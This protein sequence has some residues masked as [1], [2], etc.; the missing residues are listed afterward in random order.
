MVGVIFTGNF[1][2]G[3]VIGRSANDRQAEGDV[4][5]GGEGEHFEGDQSLIMI[6]ADDGIEFFLG[7]VIEKGVGRI[8]AADGE[9]FFLESGNGGPE[10]AFFFIAKKS[11]LAGVRIDT[12]DGD[13]WLGYSQFTQKAD[14][15][16]GNVANLVDGKRAEGG[17]QA[18]MG[19]A[20]GNGQFGIGEDHD[21]IGSLGL[22]AVS[23][24]FG[25]AGIAK[26]D[27]SER[28][29]LNGAGD[30]GGKFSA[31]PTAEGVLEGVPRHVGGDTSGMAGF[32]F[33]GGSTNHFIAKA[34]RKMGIAQRFFYD[35]RTDAGGIAQ[36]DADD[37]MATGIG[38]AGHWIRTS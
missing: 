12:G 19:R 36:G 37:G 31:L 10:N 25:L 5:A 3:A 18:E 22:T 20:E 2:S 30:N 4:H 24:K 16:L 27:L 28:F 9:M 14:G 21:G 29:F 26:T 34:T 33:F 23:K 6:G 1:E 38:K 7:G 11:V 35:F 15:L 32:D 8:R 17:A 13:L